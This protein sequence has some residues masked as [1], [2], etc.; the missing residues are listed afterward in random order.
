MPALTQQ[1]TRQRMALLRILGFSRPLAEPGGPRDSQKHRVRPFLI[2]EQGGVSPV[3]CTQVRGIGVHATQ[4]VMTWHHVRS[5][6]LLCKVKDEGESFLPSEN[7]PLLEQERGTPAVTYDYK[8]QNTRCGI[9]TG[10]KLRRTTDTQAR[11]AGQE[12]L[13]ER[14]HL[15]WSLRHETGIRETASQEANHGQRQWW[16]KQSGAGT[17]CRSCSATFVTNGE[18]LGETVQEAE[19]RRTEPSTLDDIEKG[20]TSEAWA[21]H[22]ALL[23]PFPL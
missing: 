1:T 3:A 21:L 14:D 12:G 5:T 2:S 13:G 22:A 19:Q 20:R 9:C 10:G 4:P 15:S 11:R 16:S 8:L 18:M 23:N 7:T 17:A 6:D